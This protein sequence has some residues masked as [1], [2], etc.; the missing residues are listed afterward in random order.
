MNQ[1]STRTVFDF[2]RSAVQNAHEARKSGFGVAKD[3]QEGKIA[4]IIAGLNEIGEDMKQ[5]YPRI[6][7]S[8]FKQRYL[9]AF[10]G[11]GTSVEENYAI[12]LEWMQDVAKQFNLPVHVC[13]DSNAS[14]ILFTVPAMT[15]VQAINPQLARN[16]EIQRAINDATQA[17]YMQPYQWEAMLSHNLVDIFRKVY[18]KNNVVSPQQKEWFAIF[19]R[20]KDH[21]KG[22]KPLVGIDPQL[23]AEGQ[24]DAATAAK[25]QQAEV[26]YTE[27]DEEP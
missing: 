5:H 18:D 2:R 17:R 22:R 11:F 3:V 26:N 14:Q 7:E 19:E 8:R 16:E 20:Y 25:S 9:D 27:V 10:A 12:Y 21:F 15:N 6:S 1:P 13:S 24:N 4:N 23:M